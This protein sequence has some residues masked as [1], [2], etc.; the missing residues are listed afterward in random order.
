MQESTVEN[1][2]VRETDQRK[3]PWKTPSQRLPTVLSTLPVPNLNYMESKP[4]IPI[5]APFTSL[6]DCVLSQP[7][8]VPLVIRQPTGPPERSP[9]TLSSCT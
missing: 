9:E 4:V 1:V 6:L 7:T 2:Q 3:S 5:V 8:P